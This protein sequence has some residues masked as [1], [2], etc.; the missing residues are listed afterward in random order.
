MEELIMKN[1][2]VNTNPESPQPRID[3]NKG[4]VTALTIA[5][6]LV[7]V[8]SAIVLTKSH[9]SRI[10][11][12]GIYE[13]QKLEL[14]TQ[15]S[16]RDSIINEWVLA[17]N[18]IESDIKK[19]TVRENMLSLQSMNPEISKDKKQEILNEIQL[20]RELIDKNKKK[21]ASLNSQL[22]KSGVNIASLQARVDSL[23]AN[24]DRHDFDIAALKTELI[25]RNFEIGQ[26]NLK[27]DTMN[28]VIAAK[29][30][31]IGKQTEEMNKAFV[32]SGTYK[33][34]KEK[35]LLVKEGGVLGLGK[36]ESLQENTINDNLFTRIDIS[37]TR[38]IPVNSK[39]AKLVTEHPANSYQMVKDD[40]NMIAYIEIKDPAAFWKISKYAVVEVNK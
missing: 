33:D 28:T 40:E 22:R 37:K 19:I 25:D 29:V 7:F 26:L 11:E 3:G 17:F 4:L 16:Q 23:S 20:I 30:N 12:A 38:T 32:V 6:I 5:L 15:L 9:K 10:V 8:F 34:L 27:V 14:A 36:K 21:I 13:N 35:G 24:I 31:T 18:E 2:T 1:D 39:S